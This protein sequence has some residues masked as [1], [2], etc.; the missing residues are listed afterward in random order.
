MSEKQ[1]MCAKK[2]EI[3][4]SKHSNK[5]YP[6]DEVL[7]NMT[8][9]E[10]SE[11]RAEQRRARKNAYQREKRSKGTGERKCPVYKPPGNTLFIS[12]I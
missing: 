9:E 5:Y 10:L 4:Y 1:K 12:S 3:T 8:K 2:L 7:K 6:P 11:W